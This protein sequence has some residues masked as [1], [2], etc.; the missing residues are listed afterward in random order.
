MFA[1]L[2]DHSP[3]FDLDIATRPISSAIVNRYAR[4]VSRSATVDGLAHSTLAGSD[5]N[6]FSS[7]GEME[8]RNSGQDIVGSQRRKEIVLS[9]SSVATPPPY[10]EA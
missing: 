8:G 3:I 9:H 6:G 1:S 4:Q 2:A 5:L 7:S 10:S